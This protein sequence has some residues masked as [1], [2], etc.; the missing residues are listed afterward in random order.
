MRRKKVPVKGL[1]L[2]QGDISGVGNWVADEILYQARLHPEQYSNTFSDEEI[3]R[4]RDS[5]L[6][7]T[8]IACSTLADSTKFPENWLM[9]HRWDK[10]KKASNVLPNGEKIMHLTV[11]GRTR[12]LRA[13]MRI[14][15]S[16]RRAE[17]ERQKWRKT[18]RMTR[19]RRK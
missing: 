2:D 5:L 15:R 11:S 12:R 7:V 6:D 16:Q 18:R 19:R 14:R 1:L 9:K 4:L 13:M 10:G 3:G 17:S 8:G